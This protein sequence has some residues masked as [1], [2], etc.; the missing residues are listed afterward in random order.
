MATDRA[1]ADHLL[2][3]V[4]NSPRLR[5]RAMFGDFAL[6][7]DNQVVG[8]ICDG[9]LYVRICPASADLAKE[10]D[11]DTPYPGAKPYY[12]VTEDQLVENENLLTIL[13]AIAQERKRLI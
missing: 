12:L 3:L 2:H 4:G 8:L 9:Q 6:Y 5:V 7:A 10:C 13:Y 11:L 1:T